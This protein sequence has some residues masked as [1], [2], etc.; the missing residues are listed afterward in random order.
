[1]KNGKKFTLVTILLLIFLFQSLYELLSNNLVLD[2][3]A[4]IAVGYYF[5]KYLDASMII[6]HPPLTF[7]ISGFPLLFMHI[8][9]PYSYKECVDIG[10]Y[11]CSQV[12]FFQSGN[13]A[14]KMALYSRIPF[15]ILSVIL[16]LVVFLFAEEIYG[17]KAAFI[18]LI[19]YTFSPTILSYNTIVFTDFLI[20]FFVFTTIYMFWKLI[21][22]G[23]SRKRLI[24]TG[25][26]F[27]LAL[28]SKF[29]AIF[30]VP[31]MIIIYIAK[32]FESK[33]DKRKLLKNLFIQSMYILI[34]GIFVLYF[35]YFFSF[36]TISES[37]PE[38]YAKSINSAIGK[39]FANGTSGY[40]ISKY[41]VENLKIPMPQY[42]AGFG[43][44]YQ[45]ESTKTKEGYLN[46]QIY[47]GGKWYYFFEVLLIKS[48]IPLILFFATILFF[49]LRNFKKELIN[50]LFMLLPIIFFIGVFIIAN[51]NLG[52]RHILPIMPFIFLFS[53]QIVNVKFRNR[54]ANIIFRFLILVM[55]AWYVASNLSIRPHYAAYFNELVGPENGHKYLL[56]S[57]LDM[58]QDLKRLRD[59]INENKIGKIKLSYHGAM[60]PAYYNISY[61][62]LPMEQYIP[63]APGFEQNN[64][65]YKEDCSKKY[66][67]IA[68]SVSNLHNYHLINQSCF[69]WLENYAPI[70]RIGYTIFVYNITK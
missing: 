55:L 3:P 42:P 33:K 25:I 23:Y 34:I 58:G 20:A 65:N 27:G 10:Y 12:M 29:T 18:S 22:K 59:Y 63:W 9:L 14:E 8:N 66:G 56:S 5:V 16:G 2:E 28:A 40:K 21:M 57:N 48:P 31:I 15:L 7:L 6:L 41:F 64:P 47:N 50:N 67:I 45:I 35:T 62:P 53:S 13:D 60:D 46:G 19:F 36:G 17:T 24:I 39:N 61:D 44:Q 49:S 1:M 54:N 37:I 30:L 26:S 69:S 11:K 43:G 70:K 32:I 52:L 38:R 68:I 4:Y 51:F